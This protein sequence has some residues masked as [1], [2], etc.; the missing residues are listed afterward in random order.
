MGLILITHDLGVVAE[1][2][3]RIAVMYAGRI[4]EQAPVDELYARPR[5]PYTVGLLDSIPRL[6][7]KGETLRD[8]AACRPTSRRS[9]RAAPSTRAAGTPQDIC[10]TD[11]SAELSDVAGPS[12]HVSACHFAEE[13]V[14]WPMASPADEV[15]LLEVQRPGQVLPAHAGASSSRRQIG[16]GQGRRRRLLRRCA[17]ARRS[18]SSA[19]PAAASPPSAGCSCAWRRRPPG[20][21]S[22]DGQDIFALNGQGHAGA[23][24]R[25]SRSSSRTRTPR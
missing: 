13:V 1:V 24:A 7:S 5:H 8:R 19:S 3:D 22:F 18:A 17:R 4:V 15:P 25:T 6:D 12:G 16:D 23:A 11:A 21:V 14:R 20:E 2:A 9:R 10:R